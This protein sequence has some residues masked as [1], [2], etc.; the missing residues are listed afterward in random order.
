MNK[1]FYACCAIFFIVTNMQAQEQQLLEYSFRVEGECG[2]CADRIEEVAVEKG[3]AESASYDLETKVLTVTIDENKIAVSEVR[4]ELAQ[5]G[6]DNGD[7][8]APDDVYNALPLCCQHRSEDVVSMD[9]MED[10]YTFVGGD[11]NAVSGYIFSLEEDEKLPM[12][13][14]HVQL[15]ESA[16]GTTTDENGY[17]ELDNS[18]VN[19]T[20]IVISYIGYPDKSVRL[21]GDGEV[22]IILSNALE[23][24]IVEITY[25][26][27]TTE[28]SFLKTLNVEKITR[29]E[30]CKA[31]CCNLSES[32]ETNPSVDV[33]YPD[34]ITGTRTIQMLGL[35]GPYVKID[36]DFVPSV[37][38]LNSIYGL[39]MT[40]GPWIE[41]IHLIKGAGSVVNGFESITG[42][43]NV[44]LKKPEKGEQLFLNLYYNNGQRSELNFN[45]R[46][47]LSDKLSTSLL[48][49]T[50][51]MTEA[52]DNNND[53]YT[54][55]PLSKD[56]LIANRWKY[57][58]EDGFVG[59][60]GL[61]V[62]SLNHEGGYHDHF[63]GEDVDHSAHWRMKNNTRRY[64][65]WSKTGYI[66]PNK[67]ERS[68]GL[69]M[70]AI[71]HEQESEFGFGKYDGNQNSYR[72]NLIYQDIL[73]ENHTI[74][75]GLSYQLDEIYEF[76]AISNIYNRNESVPG[77]FAEYNFTNNN[78]FTIIPGLRLDKH[79]NYGYFITPRLHAKYNFTDNSV[80]KL[81]VGRGLKTAN[82]FA[83]NIGLFS[84]SRIVN[85]RGEDDNNPYGLD[86][87]I[88]WNM[89]L[90][91]LQTV[92]VN[93][94][95]LII[96]ADVYRTNFENQIVADFEEAGF[97]SFYNLDG[98]SFS[99]SYQVKLEYELFKN[100]D[101]RT[102]FRIFDVQ[103]TYDSGQKEKPMVARERAFINMAYKTENDWHFDF[104]LN[105][106]GEQRLPDTS[107]NPI[108]FQR[109]DRAPAY[110][111]GN[112]QIMK[113]W[114]TKWDLYV[115]GENIFNYRQNDA[116]IAGD[117]PFGQ[118][119][120]ASIVWAPLF[121]ANWY[122][123]MR[124]TLN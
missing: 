32:F 55:M 31:A 111:L 92:K 6:H 44:E 2:M 91:Y 115:G 62:S 49:H 84:S 98:K 36:R 61:K 107:D 16:F 50:K 71:R 15:G 104:T 68:F 112:A 51:H 69:Q 33:S 57:Q 13:G 29:E 85:V 90:S 77:V 30:L 96:S 12:I 43:I 117:D 27:R 1:I 122:I 34:A 87:E 108:E 24:D 66:F 119:F 8:M 58:N 101:V 97:V 86:A 53:G 109:P 116:I 17:F 75:F 46:K 70:S 78:K 37:R 105:W 26:K 52:H 54:D 103:M 14:A 114:G 20:E 79:N 11:V 65:M 3:G 42:Q 74:R 94:K 56:Y 41:N 59:Q 23:L 83:E 28:L 100:F 5:A 64:E 40:P 19:A 10:E 45:T 9:E 99:N 76:V 80:V 110:F 21:D 120:D 4:W 124:Y 39:S 35:A 38:G 123:G 73:N 47:Q 48:F 22:E 95:D 82:I 7:F 106:K 118:Y 121:G 72:A 102:A 60:F 25:K 67:P 81:V 63:S 89:G 18:E 113:R 93:E 88:A